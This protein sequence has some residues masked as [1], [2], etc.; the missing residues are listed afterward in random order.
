MQPETVSVGWKDGENDYAYDTRG[1]PA[2]YRSL[3]PQTQIFSFDAK[4]YH[5]T[6]RTFISY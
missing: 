3:S 1:Q 5:R 4:H 6:T 2:S